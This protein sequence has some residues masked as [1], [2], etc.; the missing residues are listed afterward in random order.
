LIG[1]AGNYSVLEVRPETG[2][3]HQIRAHLASLGYPVVCDSLYGRPPERGGV[4]GVRLS[5]FK[6]SWRGNPAD[7]RPLLNRLGL[8]AAS[9]LLP[10]YASGL[11]ALV[12]RAPLSRD[13]RAL[14]SQIA[15]NGRLEASLLDETPGVLPG[16]V[17]L[18]TGV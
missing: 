7:E 14:V 2:R 8:H 15:K 5:S 11:A 10:E 1:G 18:A 13:M 12:L 9:V 16:E 4:E 6:R 3:T 17:K